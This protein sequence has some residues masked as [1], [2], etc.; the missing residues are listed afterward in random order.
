[1]ATEFVTGMRE[2]T[3]RE[4]ERVRGEV[5]IAKEELRVRFENYS[6]LLRNKHIEL[7]EQL[8]E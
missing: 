6:Q 8:D 4:L 2:E 1:M 7:S 3:A 5:A